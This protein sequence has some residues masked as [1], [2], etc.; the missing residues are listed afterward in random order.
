MEFNPKDTESL[1]PFDALLD[2]DEL[3]PAAIGPGGVF[4]PNLLQSE[5]LPEA[6]EDTLVC[7]RGPCRHYLEIHQRVDSGNTVDTPGMPEKGFV[8]INRYCT[9]PATDIDLMD[10]CIYHCNTWDPQ[11]SNDPEYIAREMRRKAFFTK[12]ENNG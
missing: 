12:K 11:D 1:D 9:Y 4:A 10:T 2:D 8:Q 7:L 6:T 5:P 3:V